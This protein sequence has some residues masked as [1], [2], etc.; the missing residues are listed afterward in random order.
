[1]T[2]AGARRKGTHG[3]SRRYPRRLSAGRRLALAA[4]AG[5]AGL[6]TV[7][8][9]TASV[10]QMAAEPGPHAGPP[11][12]DPGPGRAHGSQPRTATAALLPSAGAYL[13][14]YVQPATYT[15]RGEIDAILSFERQLGR[16]LGLVHVYHPWDSPF[17][18]PAD[19][20]FVR[21]AKALLL[22]WGGTPDTRTI[23]AGGYDALI[24]R[25]AEAV[26][27][28][29]KPIMLEFRHEMDRTNLQ[30]VVHS[31][32]DY[33]A[34]WDHIRAIFRAV[35]ATNVSWVWCPTAYGFTIGR[36]QAYYPGN[37]EVD[38][39]CA[40]AYSPS[41]AVPLSII[42]SPFLAWA[43]QHPKPAI[44]GEFGVGG[45][46]ASW[47]AW[48]AAAGRLARGDTQIKAMSYFSGDGTDSNGQQYAYSMG[49]HA[50]ATKA[51]ARLLAEPYFVSRVPGA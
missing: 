51:F 25:R 32:A 14:A 4:A 36:A 38:F 16:P 9:A 44:I 1:M 43:A 42:A 15:T 19:K 39:V 34:A 40:D 22:T 6:V 21:R 45:N 17:P 37:S 29:G 2:R 35:G 8:A 24:R 10:R 31:P 30:G 13:G 12:S 11:R 27:H 3:R 28:L 46:P 33:I 5:V 20:Y 47:P 48:L 49:G 26:K 50:A 7:A 23:A 41:P 18:S